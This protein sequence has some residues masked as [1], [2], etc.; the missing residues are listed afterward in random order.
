[1]TT[2]LA[3]PSRLRLLAGFHTG[4]D[5]DLPP[6]THLRWLADPALGLPL[7]P[8]DVWRIDARPVALD[9]GLLGWF[10]PDGQALSPG[11]LA[12]QG[13]ATVM[14][15]KAI[16]PWPLTLGLE[17]RAS[18]GQPVQMR[19][20]SPTGLREIARRSASPCTLALTAPAHL[21]LSGRHR[22]ELRGWQ[23]GRVDV[24]KAL[25]GRAADMRLGPPVDE[26]AWH[27]GGL[28]E[29]EAWRRVEAGA[30]LQEPWIDRPEA[31]P[32]PL[33]PADEVSR[34]MELVPPWRQRCRE[35]LDDPA[36]PPR[37]RVET[38]EWTAGVRANGRARPWQ[39]ISG[40]A[41]ETLHAAALDT[42]LARWLGLMG[43]LPSVPRTRDD[44]GREVGEALLMAGVF[45]ER[46][47]PA[48]V[49]DEL[50]QSLL[51]R[52][53]RDDPRLAAVVERL[54]E[55]G[56]RA[57]LQ[58]AL[59]LNAPLPDRPLAP[60]PQA[61]VAQW[62]RVDEADADAGSGH[63]SRRLLLPEP[64]SAALLGVAVLQEGQWVP[65]HERSAAL[66]ARS[67]VRLPGS[68]QAA[69]R[70]RLGG[71]AFA[72]VDESGLPGDGAP[73]PCRIVLGDLFGRYGPAVDGL[74]E[75]P[76]RPPVPVPAL[77]AS[78]RR[79]WPRGPDR[80][81]DDEGA[82]ERPPPEPQPLADPLWW[83]EGEVPGPQELPAGAW[84]VA[85]WEWAL[86]G[87]QLPEGPQPVPLPGVRW[88]RQMPVTPASPM[89]AVTSTLALRFIDSQ[90][91]I[92]EW[93]QVRERWVDGRLPAVPVVG[94]GLCWTS[95]PGSAPEVVL[96]LSVPAPQADAGPAVRC[97][98]Y[99]GDPASLGVA[100]QAPDG[101]PRSRAEIGR[102]SAALPPELSARRDAFRLALPEPV[103]PGAD[104]RCSLSLTLPRALQTVQ[105]LRIVPVSDSGQEP[106]FAQC[107]MLPVAVPTD[108]RPPAPRVQ[109]QVVPD[110]GELRV[111][112]L[113]EGLDRVALQ[114]DEPG[115]LQ[116]DPPPGTALPRWRLRMASGAV[117]QAFYA[118]ILAEG[119]L[120]W[121]EADQAFAADW[122][123]AREP[124]GWP[125]YVPL[126]LWAEVAMPPE[127][128]LPQGVLPEPW[129]AGAIQMESAAALQ[130]SPRPYSECSAP[131]R[132][133]HVPAALPALDPAG[134]QAT[135]SP[136]APDEWSLSLDIQG[137]ALHAMA[138]GPCRVEAAQAAAQGNWQAL[139]L[140]ADGALVQGRLQT[141]VTVQ[142]ELPARLWLRLIDPL[143][144][145]QAA[146]EVDVV[147]L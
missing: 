86:D 14:L 79:E 37:D 64:P 133:I 20:L 38:H 127:R 22:T 9:P 10:A 56:M 138:L 33:Q 63:F 96:R 43:H 97:R 11:D 66:P 1:M 87:V 118:R 141:A 21:H 3:H 82:D 58:L 122:S 40:P 92:G 5:P 62:Q 17:A 51:A 111:R 114:A 135:S 45:A 140:P 77:R 2:A 52:R 99:W 74:L 136:V 89:Q 144:T 104:G 68:L 7:S 28:G 108:R 115:C 23:V 126:T 134:I 125:A 13:G 32:Q 36:T 94:Q 26:A 80:P 102:L 4:D 131:A 100:S 50:E 146:L 113:A 67:R 91:R 109:A 84:P 117:P 41:L 129:P 78:L 120:R 47:D 16:E 44:S 35:L 93:A 116:A 137:P 31:P 48:T 60:A 54:P 59:A 107:P 81:E 73:W 95:V 75:P 119:E 132:A 24:F 83:A 103:A 147:A 106:S 27:T 139:R 42:G 12:A 25:E 128:R 69:S 57:R 71:G 65:R 8:L 112:I 98:V 15:A 72:M 6:G 61:D 142:G 29:A 110:T 90:G 101:T 123:Q 46:F 130:D 30:P 145:A 105:M 143:G 76:P 53:L 39:H 49:P 18:H 88:E 124:A 34:L 55:H 70:Q 19:L 121:S 85:L